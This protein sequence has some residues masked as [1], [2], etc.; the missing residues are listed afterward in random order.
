MPRSAVPPAAVNEGPRP[1]TLP[2][3]CSMH[4]I[5]LARGKA[6]GDDVFHHQRGLAGLQREAAAQ[7]HGAVLPLG[8]RVRAHL[9]RRANFVRYQNSSNAG[10]ALRTASN[11]AVRQPTVS[12][13]APPRVDAAAP[14]PHARSVTVEPGRKYEVSFEQSGMFAKISRSSLSVMVFA[15]VLECDVSGPFHLCRDGVCGGC[16][17]SRL[18]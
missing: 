11:G 4:W 8:E 2:P 5:V 3:A 10:A 6:R 14:A 15:P 1:T 12:T 13:V 7:R 18:P 16:R 17:V 9:G